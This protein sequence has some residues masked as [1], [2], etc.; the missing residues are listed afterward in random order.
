MSSAPGPDPALPRA[1]LDA[2]MPFHLQLD[3]EGLIRH[4][5]PSLCKLRPGRDL[6]GLHFND[7]LEVRSL[8]GRIEVP[9]MRARRG[10]LLHLR[11]RDPPQTALRAQIVDFAHSGTMLVNLALGSSFQKEIAAYGLDVEDFAPTDPTVEMLF[12]IEANASVTREWHSLVQHLDGARNEAE[13]EAS[14]DPLTGLSNRRGFDNALRRLAALQV[15]FSTMV[16]DLDYFKA[17]NDTHGHSVGDAML[18]QMAEVLTEVMRDGDTIARI[19][20]DEFA[21]LLPE[22][23]TLSKLQRIADRILEGLQEPMRL[24]RGVDVSISASIGTARFPKIQ[25]DQVS[26]ALS[27]ADRALYAAK[28]DGR[29]RVKHWPTVLDPAHPGISGQASSA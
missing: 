3:G 11:F 18:T 19:G 25:P 9:Q 1:A 27:P 22:V 5:G 4:A 20:G 17:V 14:T 7:V 21:V 2:L 16:I 29:G 15:P 23:T 24:A 13:R 6:L 10:R 8:P 28:A 12:L 26:E